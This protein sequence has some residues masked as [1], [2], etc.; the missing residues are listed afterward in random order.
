LQQKLKK[1]LNNSM[2]ILPRPGWANRAPYH[3]ADQQRLIAE[4]RVLNIVK[5]AE[6]KFLK[7]LQASGHSMQ[8]MGSPQAELYKFVGQIVLNTPELAKYFP[9]VKVPRHLK[10]SHIARL[11]TIEGGDQSME[12]LQA[13]IN[14]TF[15]DIEKFKTVAS[16][17]HAGRRAKST[18]EVAELG[19]VDKREKIGKWSRKLGG[20]TKPEKPAAVEPSA[21]EIEGAERTG[22]RVSNVYKMMHALGRLKLKTGETLDDVLREDESIVQ[23]LRDA[24][25]TEE[26]MENLLDLGT[27]VAMDVYAAVKSKV[28]AE[29]VKLTARQADQL[30]QEQRVKARQHQFMIDERYGR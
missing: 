3:P 15:D 19:E 30:L 21:E 16:E 20:E 23:A 9:D 8:F 7:A 25:T 17:L 22:A 6:Q 13:A 12:Q 1:N 2:S 5:Q 27:P 28:Q 4:A 14:D 18:E 26:F 24:S 11:A 29:S 10:S